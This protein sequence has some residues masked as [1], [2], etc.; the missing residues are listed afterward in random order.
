MRTRR[1]VAQEALQS[2][3]NIEEEK[4]GV[5]GELPESSSEED[6]HK[7]EEAK[8]TKTKH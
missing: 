7:S 1:I 2:Q 5:G 6:V 4:V 3:Q 8:R